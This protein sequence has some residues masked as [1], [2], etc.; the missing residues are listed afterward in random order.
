MHDIECI[1]LCCPNSK[2]IIQIYSVNVCV[3][4]ALTTKCDGPAALSCVNEAHVFVVLFGAFAGAAAWDEFI[5]QF[6]FNSDLFYV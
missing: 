5:S 2:C 4:S 1:L 3:F 6:R